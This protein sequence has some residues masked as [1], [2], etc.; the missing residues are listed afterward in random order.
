MAGTAGNEGIEENSA[1]SPKLTFS[2][3]GLYFSASIPLYCI[4]RQVHPFT[5]I[6]GKGRVPE[7]AP[8]IYFQS[9]S[10]H[11]FSLSK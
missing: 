10:R 2:S 11:R 3:A 8:F 4:K 5:A 7:V 9:F 1:V 6:K